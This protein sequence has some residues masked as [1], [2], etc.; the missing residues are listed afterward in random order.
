MDVQALRRALRA[1]RA[2]ASASSVASNAS[3]LPSAPAKVA[4]A[5]TASVARVPAPAPSPTPPP[6]D[7]PSILDVT[8]SVAQPASPRSAST[9]REEAD[10]LRRAQA[11]LNEGDAA[12]ALARLD[13]LGIRHPDGMLREERLASRVVALCAAGRASEARR[14]AERF[15]AESPLSIHAGR[16]R[17]SCA[18]PA[19]GKL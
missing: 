17:A 3:E 18:F 14:E 5:V 4:V 6:M 16:V 12:T 19:N 7:S 11:S 10:L 1:E 9:L 15:L 2:I 13:E 8:Q